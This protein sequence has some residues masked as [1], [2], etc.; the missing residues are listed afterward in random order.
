MFAP[1]FSVPN[2]SKMFAPNFSVLNV[3]MTIFE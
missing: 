3:S 2:V 1:N